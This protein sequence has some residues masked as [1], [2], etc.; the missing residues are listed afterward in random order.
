MVFFEKSELNYSDDEGV[1]KSITKYQNIEYTLGNVRPSLEIGEAAL[2]V[3]CLYELP[4][5]LS[6]PLL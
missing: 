4:Y 3:I 6:S 1:N 5:H 2:D